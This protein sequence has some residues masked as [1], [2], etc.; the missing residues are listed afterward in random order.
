MPQLLSLNVLNAVCPSG[1]FSSPSFLLF[2]S[3]LD[4]ACITECLKAWSKEHHQSCG[5]AYKCYLI[6]K[7]NFFLESYLGTKGAF[8]PHRCVIG[9]ATPVTAPLIM[10]NKGPTW[11]RGTSNLTMITIPSYCVEECST[12]HRWYLKVTRIAVDAT[13]GLGVSSKSHCRISSILSIHVMG[14][15]PHHLPWPRSMKIVSIKPPMV[16]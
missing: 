9:V 10:V 13:V 16:I 4:P 12:V 15:V 11:T 8:A 6:A 5:T 1:C 3:V 2:L 7:E 14:M